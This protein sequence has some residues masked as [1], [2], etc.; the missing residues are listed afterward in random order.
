M[1]KPVAPEPPSQDPAGAPLIAFDFDGTLT[2]RDS[3]TAFLRWRVRGLDR[4]RV[5]AKLAPAALA[6]LV[7]HDRG[8]LK[9]AAV[10]ACLKGMPRAQLAQ[11][12]RDFAAAAFDSL[13]RP[14]ALERWRTHRAE[15]ARVVIVTASPEE[16]VEPF[17]EHLGA[18]GLIGSRLAWTADGRVGDGLF[19][20]NCRGTEKVVRLIERFGD[21]G[22]P[23]LA[24]GD[25][26][27]DREMLAFA[28]HGEMGAFTERPTSGSSRVPRT[29]SPRG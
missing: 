10:A 27:G 5:L 13:M 18:D 11:E 26:A 6:Y 17:A 21:A 1:S 23:A 4:M 15:G 20:P 22:C 19:G 3:F 7:D 2:V 9:S 12:A 24:Y 25:T 28:E 16:I 29:R 14:D 8:G